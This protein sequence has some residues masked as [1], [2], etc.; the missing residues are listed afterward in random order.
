MHKGEQGAGQEI[1]HAKSQRGLAVTV[2][3]EVWAAADC[4]QLLNGAE[5]GPRVS[6]TGGGGR[7]RLAVARRLERRGTGS[8]VVWAATG[9]APSG[10]AEALLQNASRDCN[11][12]SSSTQHVSEKFL[13]Q[14]KDHNP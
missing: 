9:F 6:G 14:R 5:H 10:E 4:T 13:G 12:C 3:V 8:E 11:A 7:S 2:R 1:V